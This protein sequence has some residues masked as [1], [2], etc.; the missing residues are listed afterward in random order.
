M[1]AIR[2]SAEPSLTMMPARNRRPD[3]DDMDDRHGETERAGA[4]D[5]QDGNGGE[6]RRAPVAAGRDEPSDESGGGEQVHHRRIEPRDPVRQ[7]DVAAAAMLGGLQHPRHL[8]E[9]G[10]ARRAQHL[11]LDR[12]REVQA[13]GLERVARAGGTGADSPVTIDRSTSVPPRR[14]PHVDR[15]PVAGQDAQG[16]CPGRIWSS[17]R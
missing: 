5:D 13:S 12:A 15:H 9:K 6:D 3:A 16:S 11:G 7:A 2:S 10:L 8:G 17:G 1:A 14:N 4:G